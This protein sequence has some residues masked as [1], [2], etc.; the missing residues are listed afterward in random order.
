MEGQA[1]APSLEPKV[2]P[3]CSASTFAPDRSGAKV[4]AEHL[5]TTFLSGNFCHCASMTS[6]SM[7]ECSQ[8]AMAKPLGNVVESVMAILRYTRTRG[9]MLAKLE[10]NAMVERNFSQMLHHVRASA[11]SLT[12]EN[13]TALHEMFDHAESPFDASHVAPM[14]RLIDELLTY[15]MS[16]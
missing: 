14:G 16:H 2:V 9:P 10:R 5:C 7:N 8:P 11:H 6:K 3:R 1:T 13:A 4:L 15:A 12:H